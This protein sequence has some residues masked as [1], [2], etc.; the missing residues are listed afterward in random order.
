MMPEDP[1]GHEDN[2]VNN[3]FDHLAKEKGKTRQ[4]VQM[5]V[6]HMLVDGKITD[7][8]VDEMF[9]KASHAWGQSRKEAEKNTRDLLKDV[10]KLKK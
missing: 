9:E 8:H 5:E 2:I 1:M 10:L 4:E 3:T 6:Y 7:P